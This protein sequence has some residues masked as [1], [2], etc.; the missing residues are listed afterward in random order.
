MRDD[1]IEKFDLMTIRIAAVRHCRADVLQGIGI[2]G[3][4]TSDVPPRLRVLLC[5]EMQH[6]D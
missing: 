3:P 1:R 5:L 6:E 4:G 2:A